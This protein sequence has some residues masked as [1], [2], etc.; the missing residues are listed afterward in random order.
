MA[1]LGSL[2]KRGISLTNVVRAEK[3]K[4]PQI[5]EEDIC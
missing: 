2:L 1:L 5:T 3:I 4:C